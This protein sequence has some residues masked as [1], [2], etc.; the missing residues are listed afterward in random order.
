[1]RAQRFD[2]GVEKISHQGVDDDVHLPVE[3]NSAPVYLPD[4]LKLDEVLAL[5]SLD[6][7]LTRL[8]Q[9]EFLDPEL[10]KP[11]ILSQERQETSWAIRAC[12]E[13]TG[14]QGSTLLAEAAKMLQEEVRLDEVVRS[15]LAALLKG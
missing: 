7:R 4:S 8:L 1:M 13:R 6:E 12:A 10:L 11:R 9:P 5:P 3:G 14:G 15:A 2:F